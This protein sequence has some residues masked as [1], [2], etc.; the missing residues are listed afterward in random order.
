M[1]ASREAKALGWS[2]KGSKWQAAPEQLQKLIDGYNAAPKEARADSLDRLT[3]DQGRS[4]QLRELLDSQLVAY[5]TQDKGLS[6]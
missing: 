5:K 4:K 1:A 6:R 2:D 3:C